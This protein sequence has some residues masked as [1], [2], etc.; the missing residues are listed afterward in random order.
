M[1]WA[2]VHCMTDISA[3]RLI[4]PWT[5]LPCGES[6][7]S[8][9][10]SWLRSPCDTHRQIRK[11]RTK[12]AISPNI[13]INIVNNRGGGVIFVKL[14]AV[15]LHMKNKYCGESYTQDMV[16]MIFISKKRELLIDVCLWNYDYTTGV[17]A[18]TAMHARTCYIPIYNMNSVGIIFSCLNATSR[19]D[20]ISKGIS[21]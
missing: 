14:F 1:R 17:Q 20:A 2:L 15:N 13:C 18:A 16:R 7:G 8:G 4:G 6:I 21:A 5:L 12:I 3:G 9:Q 11:T 10:W 19:Q